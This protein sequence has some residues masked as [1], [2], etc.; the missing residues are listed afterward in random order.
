MPTSHITTGTD[1]YRRVHNCVRTLFD[2][3]LVRVLVKVPGGWL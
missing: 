3:V 1:F 2:R